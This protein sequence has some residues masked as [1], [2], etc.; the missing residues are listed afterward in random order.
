MNYK[1]L[2]LQ[3][4]SLKYLKSVLTNHF[5]HPTFCLCFDFTGLNFRGMLD[6]VCDLAYDKKLCKPIGTRK[7]R[8]TN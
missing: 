7:C 8:S 2:L 1:D 4:L 5:V 3:L 6:H